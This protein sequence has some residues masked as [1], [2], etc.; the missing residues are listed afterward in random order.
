M[1]AEQRAWRTFASLRRQ[2]R[3]PDVR[4][5][6]E[7]RARLGV[8]GFRRIN[9]HLLQPMVESNAWR[10][11]SVGLIDATDLPAACVA[12]KSTGQYSADRAALGGC[13]L[14]TGQS[15]CFVGYKN[16]TLRL[17]LHD[18]TVGVRLVPL[19]IWV[20]PANVS[21]GGLLVPSLHYCQRQWDWCPPLVVA[22]MGYLEAE[23]APVP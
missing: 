6:H 16:H 5:L 17:W 21:E 12:L 8:A 9:Q 3:V 7:F 14:N 18:Y 23:E 10:E 20:T 11:G 22:D 13:T 15:R 2:S 19:V 1:L 4:M